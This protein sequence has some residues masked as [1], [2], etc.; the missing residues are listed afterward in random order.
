[1]IFEIG[2]SFN[3]GLLSI[4]CYRPKNMDELD[5]S[6]ECFRCAR[7]VDRPGEHV[8]RWTAFH[9][10]LDLVVNLDLTTL[11]FKRYNRLDSEHIK[12]NHSKHHIILK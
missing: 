7:C 12:A 11:R 4:I 9:F 2:V 5:F 3:E 6:R 8:W 1:M 10:G